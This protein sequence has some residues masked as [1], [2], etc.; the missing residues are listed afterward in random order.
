MSYDGNHFPFPTATQA[1][2]NKEAASRSRNASM[3]SSH[4]T[5]SPRARHDSEVSNSIYPSNI[6]IT[7]PIH[8]SYAF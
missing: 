4:L 3:Q 2:A 6:K 5:T 8:G 1:L 7:S